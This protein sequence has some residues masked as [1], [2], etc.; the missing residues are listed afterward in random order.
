MLG[1]GSALLIAD[2]NRVGGGAEIERLPDD[3][4]GFA[5]AAADTALNPSR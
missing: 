2:T 5:A 1:Q 4:N 3:L